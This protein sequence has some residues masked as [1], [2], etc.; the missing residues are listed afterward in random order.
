MSNL[1]PFQNSGI[2]IPADYRA[3]GF[4]VA[5]AGSGIRHEGGAALVLRPAML[6]LRTQEGVIAAAHYESIIR[7]QETE[8]RGL[9]IERFTDEGFSILSAPNETFGVE[10]V[11]NSVGSRLE[12]KLKLLT[13]SARNAREW[14]DAINYAVIQYL[15]ENFRNGG[16]LLPTP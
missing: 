2:Q 5:T 7:V 13:F 14:V 9:I 8:F 3:A 11:Y 15:E 1:V 16:P 4:V 10:I 6:E 12:R